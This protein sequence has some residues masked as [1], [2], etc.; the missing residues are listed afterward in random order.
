VA[1]GAEQ[2]PAYSALRNSGHE[3]GDFVFVRAQPPASADELARG[4]REMLV[5][6]DEDGA[7]RF[8]TQAVAADPRHVIAYRI[9][10]GALRLK[11]DKDR[12]GV[13]EFEVLRL[14]EQPRT[15]EE[16]E[17]RCYALVYQ[18]ANAEE[19][20]TAC[21]EAV[22]LDP[23]SAWAY[24]SR[25]NAYL[26]MENYDGAV[27]DYTE[28]IKL[29]P[30]QAWSYA[31]RGKAR[32]LQGRYDQAIADTTEA[33]KLRPND[34]HTYMTRGEAF[35]RKAQYARAISDL[36]K[37][38]KLD[39]ESAPALR[40]RAEAYRGTGDKV[41]AAADIERARLLESRGSRRVR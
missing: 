7:I 32:L 38:I 12:A 2:T 17:A 31:N 36:T 9:R 26:D 1:G 20:V 6:G 24:H 28:A 34:F 16:H 21:A 37:A 4:A 29:A 22:K 41:R 39:P 18:S 13:D 25:G 11:G 19:A 5:R 10:A 8:S 27:K 35:L 40:I 30:R 14:L 33:A 15:A 23:N 3:S